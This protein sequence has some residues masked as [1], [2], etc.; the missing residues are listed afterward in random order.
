MVSAQDELFAA[1]KG[2][3]GRAIYQTMSQAHS[4]GKSLAATLQEIVDALTDSGVK[5]D[6]HD[7]AS[8]AEY[9]QFGADN[10]DSASA[11]MASDSVAK[12]VGGKAD[13]NSWY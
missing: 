10:V 2:D 8:A 3:T 7:V 6:A 12:S 11:G 5:I 9:K 13:L 1:V 4:S